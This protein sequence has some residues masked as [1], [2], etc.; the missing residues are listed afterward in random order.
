M[1]GQP[2][3][4]FDHVSRRF[5]TPPRPVVHAVRHF[6]L[7]CAAG[8]VT[9]VVGPSG[10][11][12]TTLLRLA[13]GLDQPTSGSVSIN[14]RR[15]SRPSADVGLVS[16]EGDLLPWRRMIHNVAL[17]LE[18]RGVSRR[19]RR[20]I[21]LDAIERV[22][23]PVD[24]AR[25]YPHELSGGMR[26]R[27]ALARALCLKQQVLL[28]DEPF[29]RLDEPIR[30]RLQ[31]ELLRIW[32]AEHQTLLFVTHSIEEAVYLADRI[33]IM[34]RGQ[35]IGVTPVDLPRPRNRLGEKF[36]RLLLD[37][38]RQLTREPDE[39]VELDMP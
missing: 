30:H 8:A 7:T 31:D 34:N 12:K 32:Q 25:A 9:C 2:T 17:G 38:R 13:A 36:V 29:S 37:V 5:E 11:G 24:A 22:G 35:C 10:C 21:A 28:M 33:V 39:A 26:Q 20:R 16:Q 3:I 1:S 14:G 23:L 4:T 18:I 27:V 15:V 19:R 6:T